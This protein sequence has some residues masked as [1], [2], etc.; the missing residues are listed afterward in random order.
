MD[1]ILEAISLAGHEGKV[2]IA[3]DVAASEFFN[4]DTKIYDLGYKS[5]ATDRRYNAEKLIEFYGKLIDKYPIKSI[6]DPFDQDDF[7]AYASMQS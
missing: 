7:A 5:G 2:K 4:P 3:L 6:E 1:L